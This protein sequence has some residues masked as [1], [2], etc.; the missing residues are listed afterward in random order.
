M[1]NI[2]TTAVLIIIFVAICINGYIQERNYIRKINE[3]K[4]QNKK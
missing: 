1:G 4:K 2:I 3:T